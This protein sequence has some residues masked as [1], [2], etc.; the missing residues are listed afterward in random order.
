MS[1]ERPCQVCE[2]KIA[3]E[4]YCQNCG[5]T[6][7]ED[8]A[9]PLWSESFWKRGD[10]ERQLLCPQCNRRSRLIRLATSIALL[11]FFLIP[12]LGI[13]IGYSPY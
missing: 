9:V 12:V 11:I 13:L 4:L 2:K 10:F 5:I 6:I 7:C 1:T 3:S 8:C